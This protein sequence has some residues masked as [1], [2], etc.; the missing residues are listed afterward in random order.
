MKQATRLVDIKKQERKEIALAIGAGI[1]AA[2]IFYI[3]I[4]C[5]LALT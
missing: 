3:V 4:F 5:A 1:I 2:P